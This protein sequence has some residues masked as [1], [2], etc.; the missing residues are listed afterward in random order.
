[1][2]FGFQFN[3]LFGAKYNIVPAGNYVPITDFEFK[4]YFHRVGLSYLLNIELKIGVGRGDKSHILFGIFF[5]KSINNIEKSGQDF[6]QET[7]VEL[8]YP[9]GTLKDF[10]YDVLSD[11]VSGKMKLESLALRLGYSYKLFN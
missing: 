11:R 5:D 2:G 3:Y 4:D 8:K 9:L 10:D 6:S 1:M 7:P